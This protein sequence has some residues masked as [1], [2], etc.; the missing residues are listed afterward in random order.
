MLKNKIK[1]MLNITNPMIDKVENG[2]A[3]IE[4]IDN[5]VMIADEEIKSWEFLKVRCRLLRKKKNK[6]TE[7]I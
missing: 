7:L 5:A 6:K 3:S 2:T 4:E 1:S